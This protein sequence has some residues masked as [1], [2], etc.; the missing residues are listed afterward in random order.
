LYSIWSVL[1]HLSL[2]FR[3]SSRVSESVV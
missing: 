3:S 2:G 1:D